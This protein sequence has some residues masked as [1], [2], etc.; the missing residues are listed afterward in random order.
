MR[1]A[2]VIQEY[3]NDNSY[4]ITQLKNYNSQCFDHKIS[5][6]SEKV[7][8][9]GLFVKKKK[10]MLWCV[11]EDGYKPKDH[12]QVTGLDTVKSSTPSIVKPMIKDVMAKILTASDN[13]ELLDTIE[14]YKQELYSTNPENIS[15][16][17]TVR[18]MSMYMDSKLEC[19]KGTPRHTRGVAAYKQLIKQ[20][21]LEGKADNIE[22]DEKVKV[23]Y[24]K[25]NPMGINSISFIRWLPEFTEIGLEIDYD[26][27]IE[28]NFISKLEQLL[29]TAGIE[30]RSGNNDDILREWLVF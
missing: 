26:K 2:E 4:E 3:V 23:V 8:Q 29:E 9:S 21:G 30:S 6:K 14:R 16:N 11:F 7:C 10:Y 27:M 22:S 25:K 1:I 28:N 13:T 19:K 24:L 15:E 5:F 12:L 20:L 18:N 17:L